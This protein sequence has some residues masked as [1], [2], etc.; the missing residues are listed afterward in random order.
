MSLHHYINISLILFATF[1]IILFQGSR[2]RLPYRND[3]K[4]AAQE[5]LVGGVL[6]AL[7]GPLIQFNLECCRIIKRKILTRPTTVF[8][9]TPL[10]PCIPGHFHY[11]KLPT[12]TWCS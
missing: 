4:I 12:P 9:C 8:A 2:L 5:D 6:V 1:Q 10:C 7:K 11:T 3:A